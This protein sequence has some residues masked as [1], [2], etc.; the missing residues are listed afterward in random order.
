M[1][2]VVAVESSSSIPKAPTSTAKAASSS[3]RAS[4]SIRTPS[5]TAPSPSASTSSHELSCFPEAG[6]LHRNLQDIRRDRLPK[7]FKVS[8]ELAGESIVFLCD[9]GVRSSFF[10]SS[11]CSPDTMNMRVDIPS[12]IVVDNCSD[13]LDVQSTGCHIGGN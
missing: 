7:F 5:P 3:I 1:F 11:S 12:H 9:Q 13:R 6:I 2:I 4:T 8:Y 10:T